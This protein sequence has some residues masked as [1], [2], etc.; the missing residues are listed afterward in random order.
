MAANSSNSAAGR[1]V[2]LQGMNRCILR[3]FQAFSYAFVTDYSSFI[4]QCRTL[5]HALGVLGFM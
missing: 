3:N 4:L 5:I 1:E 2:W